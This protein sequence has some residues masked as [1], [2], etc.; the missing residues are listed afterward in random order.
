MTYSYTDAEILGMIALVNR[1]K[2]FREHLLSLKYDE[3]SNLLNSCKSEADV[4]SYDTEVIGKFTALYRAYLKPRFSNDFVFSNGECYEKFRVEINELEEYDGE[5]EMADDIKQCWYFYSKEAAEKKYFEIIE[6]LESANVK[7]IVVMVSVGFYEKDTL[8]P[9][10]DF[11][12]PE[13][14]D[15]NVFGYLHDKQFL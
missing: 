1:D 14:R 15:Y 4:K 3:I 11:S 7:N 13:N 2:Y 9:A 8:A 5:L 6:I 10:D 12:E